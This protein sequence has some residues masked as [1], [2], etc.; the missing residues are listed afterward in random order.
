MVL[1]R[2]MVNSLLKIKFIFAIIITVVF[3]TGLVRGVQ[4]IRYRVNKMQEMRTIVNK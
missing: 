2:D 3:F 4:I 1:V